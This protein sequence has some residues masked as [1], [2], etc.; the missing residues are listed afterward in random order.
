MAPCAPN[1]VRAAMPLR[2]APTAV[3]HAPRA[4]SFQ[5]QDSTNAPHVRVS[6]PATMA[7]IL[8]GL[9]VFSGDKGKYADQEHST[10]CTFCPVGRAA[11]QQ[12][13]ATCESAKTLCRVVHGLKTD[14]SVCVCLY[15]VMPA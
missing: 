10:T 6:F 11:T 1:A 12:G 5:R 9:F 15:Q 14:F 8:G 2:R 7:S 13:Q 3:C 4:A